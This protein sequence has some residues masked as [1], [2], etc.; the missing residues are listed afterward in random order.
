M[1]EFAP[2]NSL[3]HPFLKTIVV[4]GA[5]RTHSNSTRVRRNHLDEARTS[6]ASCTSQIFLSRNSD[7]IVVTD[8]IAIADL[9]FVVVAHCC[10]CSSSLVIAVARR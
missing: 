2:P 6:C 8:L 7:L 10:R 3:F 4:K 9:L 1:D 5:R